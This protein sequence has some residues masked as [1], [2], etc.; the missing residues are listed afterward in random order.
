MN[1]L[2]QNFRYAFRQLRKSPGFAAVALLTLALGIGASTAMF[3]VLNAVLLRPVSFE[4]PDRLVRIFSTHSDTTEGPSPLDLRD[5]A[6][7]NHTFEKMA[8]YDVWRKNVST[9][10]GSIE[11]EQMRV[12]LVPGEYFEVL[13]VRPLM[14]R[15][16]KDEENR[17]GNN[18]V[19]IISYNFWQTRFDGDRS[20]LGKTIRIND[21]PYTIIAVTPAEVPDWWIGNPPGKTEVWTPFVPYVSASDTVWA[22][23]QR[24]G[25]GWGAI[26]RLKPRVTIDEANADLQRIADNLAAQYPLDRGVGVKLRPLQEDQARNLRPALRLLMGA[27]ILIL[28]IACS[29]VANL[30]LARNSTRT[31]EIALRTAMGAQPSTLIRQFTAES[32]VLGLLGGLVGCA[33]AWWGCA[34]LARVH[35]EQLP[36]LSAVEVDFRVLGFAFCLSVISSLVFGTVPAW[37]SLKVSPAEAFKEGGRTNTGGR[38]GRR[39]GRIF[40]ISEMAFALMLLIGTGL[41]MQSLL[42]LQNQHTGFRADHLLRTHLFLPPVRYADTA[43][44]TRFS[45]E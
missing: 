12:G 44:I 28:L 19:A 21:E 7:Q 33:L 43:S 16:F 35:P 39:L 29:N 41:L 4:N 25:R 31:R 34:T 27:V 17:W 8:V 40:V 3:G 37:T 18:F 26:G 38:S 15:L 10:N 36:Q 20:I 1:G 23:S 24:D 6:A 5:F 32:L 11:P 13:G 30:L 45:D 22:E 9:E 14:G 2:L 42:R